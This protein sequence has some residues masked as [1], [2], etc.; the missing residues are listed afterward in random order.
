MSQSPTVSRELYLPREPVFE[1]WTE[2]EHLAV[3][4]PPAGAADAA[5]VVEPF[6]GGRFEVTWQRADGAATGERGRV[7]AIEAPARLVLTM[8][9]EELSGPASELAVTFTDGVD[10]C[11]IDVRQACADPSSASFR[12][13]WEARLDRL[14]QYF[15]VV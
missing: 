14:E 11:R 4:Y 5:A 3:W 6:R 15:S 1:A 12:A 9:A 7:E 13:V 10:V 2:A 8:D